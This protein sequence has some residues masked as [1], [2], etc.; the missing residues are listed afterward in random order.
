MY[1]DQYLRLSYTHTHTY[2]CVYVCIYVSVLSICLSEKVSV[3]F[4]I[5]EV[6]GLI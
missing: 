3:F 1:T 6:V 2:V 4:S 5:L